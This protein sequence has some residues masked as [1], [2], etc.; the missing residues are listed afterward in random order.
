MLRTCFLFPLVQLLVASEKSYV[1]YRQRP[2]SHNMR[3]SQVP[4]FRGLSSKDCW[5]SRPVN[6]K[7]WRPLA[8]VQQHDLGLQGCWAAGHAWLPVLQEGPGCSYLLLLGQLVFQ[9]LCLPPFRLQDLPHF[10]FLLS[11]TVLQDLKGTVN[12]ISPNTK[13]DT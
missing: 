3:S 2:L 8:E 6:G 12:N 11:H 10:S 7:C 13:A 1:L 4:L 5:G 9:V